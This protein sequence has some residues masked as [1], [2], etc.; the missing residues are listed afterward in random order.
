MRDIRVSP[1]RTRDT[2]RQHKGGLG[3]AGTPG[4]CGHWGFAQRMV[5]TAGEQRGTPGTLG[6]RGVPPGGQLE[7]LDLDAEEGD[8]GSGAERAGGVEVGVVRG[9]A[10]HHLLVV[11]QRAAALAPR[12]AGQQHLGG[13]GVPVTPRHSPGGDPPTPTPQLTSTAGGSCPVAPSA[14]GSD[15]GTPVL[16]T[17]VSDRSS[18][19]PSDTELWGG[20]TRHQQGQTRTDRQTDRRPPGRCWYLGGGGFGALPRAQQRAGGAAARGGLPVALLGVPGAGGGLSAGWG[21]PQRGP[22]AGGQQLLQLGRQPPPR[23][24]PPRRRRLVRPV[25][26]VR[27]E[28]DVRQAPV[29]RAGGAAQPGGQRL[30]RRGDRGGPGGGGL[31]RPPP[32]ALA[33]ETEAAAL[34]QPGRRGGVPQAAPGPGGLALQAGPGRRGSCGGERGGVSEVTVAPPSPSLSP[35]YPG[36]RRRPPGAPAAAGAA[37]TGRPPAPRCGA[38]PSA[39]ARSASPPATCSLAPPARGGHGV[40]RRRGHPPGTPG[41]PHDPSPCCS[42]RR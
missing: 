3:T 6:F 1:Q 33:V 34:H 22:F 9:P 42:S 21:G 36:R 19:L 29:G 24:A 2:H 17:D 14:G 10:G 12:A 30:R 4:G 37:E 11:H 41:H 13:S 35:T 15:L 40:R 18:S 23:R 20:D 26:L 8:E 16:P 39:G 25:A 28:A 27:G 5:D 38:W 7:V 31:P 32:A